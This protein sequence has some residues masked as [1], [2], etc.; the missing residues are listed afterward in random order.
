EG[1]RA[2]LIR[3]QLEIARTPTPAS[4]DEPN[5]EWERR[6]ARVFA[7]LRDHPEW[8]DFP[9]LPGVSWTHGVHFGF[10][11]GFQNSVMVTGSEAF[12]MQMGQVFEKAPVTRVVV[13]K[14]KS[15]PECARQR[16]SSPAS[17]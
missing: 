2:E 13:E 3:L 17:G 15:T 4:P 6:M 5:E 11:R 16:P 12:T 8:R 10:A 7:L 1:E 14:V 9:A